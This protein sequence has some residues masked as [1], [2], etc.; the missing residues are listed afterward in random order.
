MENQPKRVAV[1][2]TGY[3]GIE[4]AGI[5]NA[6]G[7]ETTVFSRTKQILRSFD[8]IIKDNLLKEMESTG[9]KFAYESKVKALSRSDS[10]IRVEYESAGQ[11]SSLEVDCVLWAVGRSPNVEK[12]NL[13][14]ANVETN[15]KGYV[16]VDDY[17]NTSS[18]GVLALGDACGNFELT[19]GKLTF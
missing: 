5:F 10:G 1:V 18:S 9:V 14:S 12:L 15:E 4:I 6:L 3:I 17:Q 8:S 13:E 11:A 2:G 7:T 19:P 16:I